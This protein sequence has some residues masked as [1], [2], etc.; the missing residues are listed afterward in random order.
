MLAAGRGVFELT[1][2]RTLEKRENVLNANSQ[3]SLGNL[4]LAVGSLSEVVT[5]AASGT[6]VE[7]ENSDH[8]ALLTSK[9]IEQIQTKGRDVMGLMRL[10]PGVRYEDSSEALGEDFGSPSDRTV[11]LV[12]PHATSLALPAFMELEQFLS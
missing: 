9:Q 10:M 3:L 11:L 8:T 7:V 4:I 1:G 5:V 6:Q 12:G 2:F